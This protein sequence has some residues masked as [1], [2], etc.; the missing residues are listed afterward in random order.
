MI[1]FYHSERPEKT[2][3]DTFGTFA[4]DSGYIFGIAF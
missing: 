2:K 3:I 4:K 1:E